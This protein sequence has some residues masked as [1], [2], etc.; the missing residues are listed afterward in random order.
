MRGLFSALV[1]ISSLAGGTAMAQPYTPNEAGV[2][3]GH[4]HLNSA[5]PVA[6]KKLFVAMGG[7]D[8]SNDRFQAVT[9][10]GVLINMNLGGGGPPATGGTSASSS[11][12]FRN[13][14]PSGRPPACRCCRA[15]TAA[16]TRP[17]W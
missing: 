3:M 17:M 6:N 2:T 5:D 9:F 13:P 14:S 8:T 7:V 1:L 16:P 12:T 10:P 11:R 4:W 15:T